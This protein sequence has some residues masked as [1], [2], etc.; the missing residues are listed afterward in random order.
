MNWKKSTTPSVFTLSSWAWMQMKAPV[1]PMPS[2]QGGIE[3][4]SQSSHGTGEADRTLPAVNTCGRDPVQWVATHLHMTVMALLPE[5]ICALITSSLSLR[6]EA[7]EG[8]P[9]TGHWV[10]WN[11]VTVM[12][13]CRETRGG[14]REVSS[15]P[16]NSQLQVSSCSPRPQSSAHSSHHGPLLIGG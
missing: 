3:W 16:S 4:C 8:W 11:C 13:S 5:A 14:W 7:G 2:L 9:S 1:R 6:R 15:V 12:D 10:Q